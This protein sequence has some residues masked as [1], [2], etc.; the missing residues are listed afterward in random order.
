M[1][2]SAISSEERLAHARLIKVD[3]SPGY[4]AQR[5]SMDL[6]IAKAVVQAVRSGIS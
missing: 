5:T 1:L 4:N 6:P 3:V 2:V